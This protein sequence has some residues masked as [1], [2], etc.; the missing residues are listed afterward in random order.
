MSQPGVLAL[1]SIPGRPEGPE[2]WC[3]VPEKFRPPAGLVGSHIPEVPTEM[4]CYLS[5]EIATLTLARESTWEAPGGRS[6]GLQQVDSITSLFL[7]WYLTAD[8]VA[9]RKC[10][11]DLSFP[12]HSFLK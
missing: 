4:V 10:I 3:R 1:P 7:G 8:L 6:T 2:P 11:S 5:S 9:G 12:C